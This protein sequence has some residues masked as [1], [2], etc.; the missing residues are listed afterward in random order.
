M[1]K[2]FNIVNSITLVSAV[3]IGIAAIRHRRKL[4]A[5]K[6]SLDDIDDT[7]DIIDTT[8]DAIKAE[9]REA[10]I[11]RNSLNAQTYEIA[12]RK[13]RREIGNMIKQKLSTRS[14]EASVLDLD[15]D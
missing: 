7:L 9:M 3:I 13:M 2:F 1:S 12:K 11:E 14:L 10:R 6:A 8:L 5:I 15:V 4:N